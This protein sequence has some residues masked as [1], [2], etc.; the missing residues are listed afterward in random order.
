MS[1]HSPI[2]AHDPIA[3]AK[4]LA[5]FDFHEFAAFNTGSFAVFHGTGVEASDWELHRDTDELLFVLEGSTTIEV[6]GTEVP[7]GT[8]LPDGA[9]LP[10]GP[11][12]NTD[13]QRIALTAGTFT[14]VP[15][16]H[17]HRHLD[18]VDLV[19][20]YFTPGATEQSD[21]LDPRVALTELP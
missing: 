12:N 21:A 5:P 10:G 18:V 7:G 3:L 4:S 2:Q 9:V 11:G 15:K 14:V 16:G 17:W 6:L 19:E 1:D 20:M 13:S 8:E